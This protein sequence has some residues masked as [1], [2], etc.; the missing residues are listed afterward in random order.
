[1]TE[2]DRRPLNTYRGFVMHL[3]ATPP[4]H[5]PLQP[6]WRCANCAEPRPCGPARLRLAAELDR[7][8]LAI[9]MAA[10]LEEYA[11]DAGEGP[12]T[13]AFERFVA[14]TR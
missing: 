13:G 5:L 4:E 6:G 14:W 2:P 9:T 3:P 7:T 12:L 11:R 8:Q 10:Y 1:M